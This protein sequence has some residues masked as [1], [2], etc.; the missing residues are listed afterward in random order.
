MPQAGQPTDF[1]IRCVA[2]TWNNL[3]IFVQHTV[4]SLA[5]GQFVLACGLASA[6]RRTASNIE[7]AIGGN[8]SFKLVFLRCAS[9]AVDV[10]EVVPTWTTKR[11]VNNKEP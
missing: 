3:C 11:L 7:A 5:H 2:K 10:V 8:E 4:L 6:F 1:L 9:D